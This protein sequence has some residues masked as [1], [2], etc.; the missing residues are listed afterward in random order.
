MGRAS[1]LI[2]KFRK[3]DRFSDKIGLPW[4]SLLSVPGVELV[5]LPELSWK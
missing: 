5:W 1:A 4:P 3:F 2:A